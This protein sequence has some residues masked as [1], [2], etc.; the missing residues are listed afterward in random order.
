MS[1]TVTPAIRRAWTT[2]DQSAIVNG[3]VQDNTW[4]EDGLGQVGERIEWVEH[5]CPKCDHTSMIRSHEYSPEHRDTVAYWCCNPICPYFVA[6]ELSYA[7]TGS[8]T[9][10]VPSKP[11]VFRERV[12]CPDCGKKYHET[13]RKEEYHR[14]DTDGDVVEQTC[15]QCEA[16][17]VGAV[18]LA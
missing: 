1:N 15:E 12:V 13:L 18:P 6:D 7:T 8:R 5:E 11:I 2:E 3:I 9:G 14:M 16:M 4:F 17:D 10:S